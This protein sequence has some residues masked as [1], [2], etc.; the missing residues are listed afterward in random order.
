MRVAA[1]LRDAWTLYRAEFGR[2]VAIAAAG[3]VVLQ[4][5]DALIA[6]AGRRVA[7][8][9]GLVVLI[10]SFLP[11][12]A[13]VHGGRRDA[14]TGAAVADAYGAA[15]RRLGTVLAVS[16]VSGLGILVGLLLLIVPGL[17]LATRWALVFQAVMLEDLP[18]R[19][20]FGRSAELVRGRFRQMLGLVL[21]TFAASAAAL[22]L[23]F[24]AE[25]WLPLPDALS[26]WVVGVAAGSV[27]FPYFALLFNAA[28]ARL[29]ARD[30]RQPGVG[31]PS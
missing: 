3:L 25:R 14:S 10:A 5:L 13:L 7:I 22:L 30:A 28:H 21:L 24:A 18:W 2:Y 4:S 31:S 9:V 16:V 29:A 27:A 11:Y 8:V 26:G 19:R 6:A 17:Y 12:A 1:V 15:T 20:A 23:V